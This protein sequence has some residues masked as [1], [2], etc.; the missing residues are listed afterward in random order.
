MADADVH[1]YLKLLTF[2]PLNV[3][4]NLME[5]HE[6]EPSKRVAQHKLAR[7][8]LEIVHGGEIAKRTEQ[9]HRSLF[10]RPSVGLPPVPLW[11]A[12]PKNGR[13]LGDHTR[14]EQ[15]R[16]INKDWGMEK[17]LKKA[18]EIVNLE[19]APSV[20]LILP[21]SLV[22]KQPISRV[23]YHAGMVSSRGEGHRLIA[24]KGVYLGARPGATGTM[25]N[26]VDFSPAANW[27]GSETERYILGGDTL[28]LRVGKWKVKIIKIINDEDFEA[29]GLSV[30]GWKEERPEKPLTHDLQRMKPWHRKGWVERTPMHHKDE[31][32]GEE[33]PY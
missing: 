21:K 9:E 2:E 29:Q 20:S 7:E 30:P 24:N 28:T 22:Y 23:L 17:Q 15:M 6:K 33:T 25:G 10:R 3:L 26:Q 11:T 14:E 4:E 16:P 5:E 19:S 27:D 1:R 31:R 12:P 13:A 8:V 18:A 32:I